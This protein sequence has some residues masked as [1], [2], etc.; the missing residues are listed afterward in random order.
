MDQAALGRLEYIEMNPIF[1]SI[2]AASMALHRKAVSPGAANTHH[3]RLKR[4]AA[5]ERSPVG[6]LSRVWSFMCHGG[7]RRDDDGQPE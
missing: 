4:S 6:L 1:T 7:T 3:R 5:S 2:I